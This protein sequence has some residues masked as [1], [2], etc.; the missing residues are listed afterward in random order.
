MSEEFGKTE[1]ISLDDLMPAPEE[2]PKVVPEASLRNRSATLSMLSDPEKVGE[3]YQ[4]MLAEGRAGSSLTANQ[5]EQQ[6][7][8]KEGNLDMRNLLSLLGS[9]S[10][11]PEIKQE[12]VKVYAKNGYLSDINGILRARSLAAPSKGESPDAERARISTAEAIREMQRES[13]TQQGLV[14]RFAAYVDDSTASAMTDLFATAILPFGTNLIT[15]RVVAEKEQDTSIW[16]TIKSGT[17]TGEQLNR[18]K[19]E[20]TN[21]PPQKRTEYVKNLISA[22]S[23]TE[24]LILPGSNH[25]AQIEILRAVTEDGRYDNLDRFLDDVSGVLDVIGLGQT[26]RGFKSGKVVAKAASKFPTTTLPDVSRTSKG[27]GVAEVAHKAEWEL[28]DDTS[29]A[30]VPKGRSVVPH[31]YDVTPKTLSVGGPRA[32]PA[33]VTK[34]DA[35]LKA[36][37]E[38]SRVEKNVAFGNEHPVTPLAVYNRTNPE[39][40]RSTV[41]AVVKSDTDEV[42]QAVAGT[43]RNQAIADQVLPKVVTENGKIGERVVDP[44]RNIYPVDNM[45][46]QAAQSAGA[47]HFTEAERASAVSKFTKEFTQASGLT[48]QDGMGGFKLTEDGRKFEI[49]AVYGTSEGAFSN[50]RQAIEQA[51]FS[52]RNYG[53]RDD[54]IDL[55]MKTGN[56]YQPVKLSDVGDTEGSYLVRLKTSQDW[57]FNDIVKFQSVDV[58]RNWL[59]RFSALVP[60]KGGA[61]AARYAMDPASMLHPVY[62]NSLGAATDRANYID[63]LFVTLTTAYSDIVSKLP[64]D[65]RVAVE[66]HLKLANEKGIA[67]DKADLIGRGFSDKEIEAIEHWKNVW[68]NHYYFENDDLV[69]TL[70]RDG[71]QMYVGPGGTELFARAVSQGTDIGSLPI[72]RNQTAGR[73]FDPVSN[74]SVYATKTDTQMLYAAGGSYAELRRPLDINGELVSHIIVRNTPSE[75][76]RKFRDTDTVLNYRPMH[77]TRSYKAARFV[78]EIGEDGFRKAIAVGPDTPSANSFAERMRS[79]NPTKQYEVRGD[80]RG[81]LRGTDDWYDIESASGR[82]AQRHRGQILGTTDGTHILG[83]GSFVVDPVN[84]AIR[85]AQSLSGRIAMREVIETAKTRAIQQYGHLFPKN[86]IGK[87][88]FPGGIDEIGT[89][90]QFTSKELADARTVVGHIKYIEGGFHNAGD[91]LYKQVINSVA[92]ELGE[93]G[94]GNAERL[95]RKAEDVNVSGAVK[96]AVFQ[97]YIVMSNFARQ[98][99]IQSNNA[100]RTAYLNPVHTATGGIARDLAN[101]IRELG[102]TSK[103]DFSKFVDASGMLAGLDKSNMVRGSLSAMAEHRNMLVEA[104]HKGLI[105]IPRRIGFD[106]GEGLNLFSYMSAVYDK[107]KRAGKDVTDK[108][109]REQMYGEVRALTGEMNRAGDM[110][111]NAGIM[112]IVTQFLQVPHK[113]YLGYTNRKLDGPTKLRMAAGDILLWGSAGGI[114]ASLFGGDILPDDPDTRYLV[115]EG[116][117]A[118]VYNKLFKELADQDQDLDLTALNPYGLEGFGKLYFALKE[119][120]GFG[121]VAAAAPAY[122]LINP[123]NGRLPLAIKEMARYFSGE[124]DPN[125]PEATMTSVADRIAKIASGYSSYASAHAALEAGKWRTNTGEELPGEVTPALA[126]AKSLGFDRMSTRELYKLSQERF[127]TEKEFKDAVMKDYKET[128]RILTEAQGM[129]R[130]EREIVIKATNVLLNKWTGNPAALRIIIQAQKADMTGKQDQL[131]KQLIKN[132]GIPDVE[133]TQ[134]QIK[135]APISDE[136]KSILLKRFNEDV[137]Q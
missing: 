96:G 45:L 43:T 99:I 67:F 92:N 37:E 27:T 132:A 34:V 36:Q 4:T 71:Y 128:Y 73:V 115:S 83:D 91:D 118:S 69:K 131:L 44:F 104:T 63:K 54:E 89:K 47:S 130:D 33:P 129:S 48:V 124:I 60:N 2:A 66:D 23:K 113:A 39:K 72:A 68:D 122:N 9:S 117:Q 97:S 135:R 32:L 125:M 3:N 53:I 94:F 61:S 51:K 1:D 90:G 25:Y 38:V 101:Y 50:A 52:L 19:Q 81:I 98:W 123:E 17:F 76:L 93:R 84:S 65:R 79:N 10:V 121:D 28:V 107:Y 103:S 77:Y 11:A 85:A 20:Y 16:N 18:M 64:L 41:E 133:A 88:V 35:L 74:S 112:S 56:D 62:S 105:E 21:M 46:K 80:D 136:Q 8:T 57:D 86:T 42:A 5:L 75:Y 55:L 30:L 70:N 6:V 106:A 29:R 134:D 100:I 87:A 13:E 7:L 126:I 58:K 110:P 26:I 78:D 14:N 31:A 102:S 108:T 12:L 119:G 116:V 40:A 82:L 127:K 109:I 95:V 49:S 59:D 24:N 15:G 137:K 114:I 120:K 22:L 111:Y